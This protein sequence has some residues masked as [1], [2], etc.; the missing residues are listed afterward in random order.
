[1]ATLPPEAPAD[2]AAGPP[3]AARTEPDAVSNADEFIVGQFT[4]WKFEDWLDSHPSRRR[5][6]ES[7]SPNEQKRNRERMARLWALR[8][9]PMP[10]DLLAVVQLAD[11]LRD[12]LD[13]LTGKYGKAE[14]RRVLED[15]GLALPRSTDVC[16]AWGGD[17]FA[18]S[19]RLSRRL[20]RE[21]DDY[22]E[23][24]WES[25]SL[26]VPEAAKRRAA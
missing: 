17:H 2:N 21:L 16:Q 13:A 8:D 11:Q 7:D 10:A 14:A 9:S 1:M 24:V 18:Q 4:D 15:A 3:S 12:K 19:H 23:V 20:I 6:H 5:A 22:S 25:I 26:L